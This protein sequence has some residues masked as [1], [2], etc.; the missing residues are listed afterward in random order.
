MTPMEE[1]RSAS[2]LALGALV[3]SM[4]KR[5]VL[6]GALPRQEAIE[7]FEDAILMVEAAQVDAVTTREVC[8]AAR[9]MLEKYRAQ[10][11]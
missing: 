1:A 3:S 2:V 6:S 9:A 7:I 5:L 11:P 10:T 8:E 4:L